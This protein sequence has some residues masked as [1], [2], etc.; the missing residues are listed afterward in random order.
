MKYFEVHIGVPLFWETT[1]CKGSSFSLRSRLQSKLRIAPQ[2]KLPN[3]MGNVFV[4]HIIITIMSQRLYAG[5]ACMRKY[6]AWLRKCTLRVYNFSSQRAAISLLVTH[7]ELPLYY[8]IDWLIRTWPAADG[9]ET[10]G[11]TTGIS[12]YTMTSI[13]LPIFMAITTTIST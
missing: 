10:V 11:D 7:A 1:I 2:L 6:C 3:S 8:A 4:Q 13:E 5:S 9:K 12:I